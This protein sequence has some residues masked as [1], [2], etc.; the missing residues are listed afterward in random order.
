MDGEAKSAAVAAVRWDAD[1]EVAAEGG[2]DDGVAATR[3]RLDSDA[4]TTDG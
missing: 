2:G 1:G 3:G 4:G